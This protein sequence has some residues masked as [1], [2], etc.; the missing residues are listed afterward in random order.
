[1]DDDTTL[2]D[3]IVKNLQNEIDKLIDYERTLLRLPLTDGRRNQLDLCKYER[4]RMSKLLAT[5][6]ES[7]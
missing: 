3:E 1:M 6:F 2:I 5:A 4:Y 7:D